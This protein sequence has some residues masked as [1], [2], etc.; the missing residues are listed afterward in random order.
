MRRNIYRVAALRTFGETYRENISEARYI[1]GSVLSH[2][3]TKLSKL[4]QTYR[5][6]VVNT[7]PSDLSQCSK[8]G[9]SGP[10]KR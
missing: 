5:K 7:F 8:N 10:K 6:E 2:M 4:Y 3:L 1:L 9:R